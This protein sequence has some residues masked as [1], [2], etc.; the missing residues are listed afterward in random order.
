M[1]NKYICAARHQV[2]VSEGEV[3][4]D[5]KFRSNSWNG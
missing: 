5:D 3:W 1:F 2:R 4:H